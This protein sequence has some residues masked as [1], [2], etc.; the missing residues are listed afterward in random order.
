MQLIAVR[1]YLMNESRQPHVMNAGARHV[2]FILLSLGTAALLLCATFGH[3]GSPDV[4][5]AQAMKGVPPTAV[6]SFLG[7]SCLACHNG[8]NGGGG[9]NLATTPFR[10]DDARNFGLWV[11]VYDRVSAG[12]MPPKS[13]A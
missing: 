2:P 9:L 3:S 7:Q 11:K 6:K 1:K 8:K 4:A 5:R 13:A 12:E 10:P